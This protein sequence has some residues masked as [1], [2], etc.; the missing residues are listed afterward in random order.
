MEEAFDIST[1]KLRYDDNFRT[2]HSCYVSNFVAKA[3]I[4]QMYIFS[5]ALFFFFF[6]TSAHLI[7]HD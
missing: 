1:K 3:K 7:Y 4:L 6:G 2:G 5:N